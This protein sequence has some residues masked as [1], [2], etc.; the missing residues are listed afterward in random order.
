MSQKFCPWRGIFLF[1]FF[2]RSLVFILISLVVSGLPFYGFAE[3]GRPAIVGSANDSQTNKSHTKETFVRVLTLKKISSVDI[4]AMALHWENDSLVSQSALPQV[5][6]VHIVYDG[7]KWII[8]EFT[9]RHI[10]EKVSYFQKPTLKIF[11]VNVRVRNKLYSD[12]LTLIAQP[13]GFDVVA[14]LPLNDYLKGVLPSEMPSRWPIEA[15]K[16]Q[17]VAAR[18]YVFEV[19]HENPDA[20]FHVD[21]TINH[22]VFKMQNFFDANEEQKLKIL[23]AISET[24]G[25]Y[26]TNPFGEP[27]RAYFHSDCGG[28]TEEPS[29]VWK[30]TLKNGTVLDEGCKLNH[31]SDWRESFTKKELASYLLKYFNLSQ[32][33]SLTNIEKLSLTQSGRVNEL[34]FTFL[35]QEI[36]DGVKSV[37]LLLPKSIFVKILTAQDFRRIVGY[38]RIKSTFFEIHIK[39]NAIELS[40][41]GYGHGAGMCQNGARYLAQSGSSYLQILKRYYPLMKLNGSSAPNK[42]RLPEITR[43]RSP[44]PSPKRL[45]DSL[46]VSSA[47]SPQPLRF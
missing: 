18:S 34:A 8:K 41:R 26:L 14:E 44:A 2:Q 29:A 23:K 42:N 40:G 7:N 31:K 5:K 36:F 12:Q 30:F 9:E 35:D 16:A 33:Y 32:K 43:D 3:D 39:E 46:T 25:Q 38:N 19:I 4:S 22:Q 1:C 24:D 20:Y 37:N 45:S 11:G 10:M 15:L 27:Y 28:V 47:S 6:K 17:A 13:N 21:D